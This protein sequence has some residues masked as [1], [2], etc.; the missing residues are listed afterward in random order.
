MKEFKKYFI[1]PASPEEVYEALTNP[2]VLETWTGDAVEMS[3][4]PGSE[5][6]LWEGSIVGKNLEFEE[7]RK[8]VQQWYFGEQE[9]PSIVTIKTHAH[10]QGTSLEVKQTNI[11]DEDYDDLVEGWEESYVGNLISF[12]E[13]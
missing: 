6:S 12:F 13:G 10:K 2:T 3:T 1:V 7:N 9:E 11:P 5:F 4:T 8:I